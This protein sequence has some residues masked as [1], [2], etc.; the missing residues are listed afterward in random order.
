MN[1]IRKDAFV[2]KKLRAS[3]NNGR[4]RLAPAG[5]MISVFLCLVLMAA[6][7]AS[8]KTTTFKTVDG[9]VVI[10]AETYT[11]LGGNLGGTWYTNK[12]KKGYK[13]ASYIQS[14]EK[15]PK[16]LRYTSGI[17]RAEYDIDF[18]ETGTYF[19]HLRTL[20]LNH[21]EN[22]FFA[23]M[24]G[25]HFDYGHKHAYFVYAKKRKTGRWLW[26]TDGGGAESR[27]HM[28]SIQITKPGVHTL[29]I[30]R[31]DK[32]SRVDRIWLTKKQSTPTKKSSLPFLKNPSVFIE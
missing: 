1:T 11:R 7:T 27:G 13:G 4:A 2:G 26:Y 19:L 17:I 32:G 25:K 15:D 30:C 21:T 10:E 14:A 5:L 8:A 3:I 18:K 22:G 12:E 29:A 28:V 31:R 9:E 24:D 23:T 16:T 6:G 20:A